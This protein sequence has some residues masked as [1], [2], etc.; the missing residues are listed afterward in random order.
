MALPNKECVGC[1]ACAASCPLGC[2]EMTEDVAGFLRPEVLSERCSGCGRC[3]AVC[4]SLNPPSH[5]DLAGAYWA[6]DT[7]ATALKAA[8]SGGVFGLLA[9]VTVDAGGAVYGAVFGDDWTVSHAR[10]CSLQGVS[11]LKKSKYVQSRVSPDVYRSVRKDLLDGKAVL[12]T[13][14]ACQIAGLKGYLG[15]MSSSELLT[16]VEVICHGAPSPRLWTQ[17]VAFLE[18]ACHS[19][20]VSF[21]F[22]EKEPSWSSYSVRAVFENGATW[23][24][25]YLDCWFM[26]AFMHDLPLRDSCYS[27]PFKRRSGSELV[28]GDF[29]GV[30]RALPGLDVRSGVSAVVANTEKGKRRLTELSGCE[31]GEVE[32]CDILAGNRSLEVPASMPEGRADFVDGIALGD[33]SEL[34]RVWSFKKS[35]RQ[36]WSG[37]ARKAV[38]TANKIGLVGCLRLGIHLLTLLLKGTGKGHIKDS[39]KE[40]VVEMKNAR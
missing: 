39:L 40:Y 10:A 16:C 31:L 14:T 30:E 4:P 19:K 29:W 13:G 5:D 26:V 7:S 36:V 33:I 37:R 9:S 23:Q 12:F 20:L 1:G 18:S 25:P 2:I 34:M 8:S 27:C 6:R 35:G 38:R 3:E 22:R 21:S 17:Y 24:V 28:L 32:Y 15:K 11:A